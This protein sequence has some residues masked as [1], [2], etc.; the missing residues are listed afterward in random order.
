MVLSDLEKQLGPLKAASKPN[1]DEVDRLK[2]LNKVLSAE[3]TEIDKLIHGSK[4]LK[5]KVIH[6][7][8]I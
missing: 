2:E 4:K 7:S 3:E 5:E 1:K 6:L 8:G